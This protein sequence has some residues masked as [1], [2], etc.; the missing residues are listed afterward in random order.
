MLYINNLPITRSTMNEVRYAWST[1]RIRENMTKRFKWDQTAADSIDWYSHGSTIMAREYY[2]RNF[3]MKLIHERLPVLGEDFSASANKVCPCCK[4]RNETFSHYI[5]CPSNPIK[6]NE[7]RDGLKPIYETH[8][9]DPM[10]RILINLALANE[11]ITYYGTQDLYPIN[12]WKP[13]KV[14]IKAQERIGWRQL[15]YGRYVLEWDQCQ[16]R[17]LTITK[18]NPVTGE[19]QWIRE[20]IQ[21]TWRYQKN[22]WLARSETLHGKGILTSQATKDAYFARITALY[23]HEAHILVQDRHPFNTPLEEW[24]SK[25]ATYM[26][27]WLG[28]NAPFIKRCLTVAKLHLKIN[29][30]D[31]R[32][33]ITNEPKLPGVKR[34]RKKPKKKPPKHRDIRTFIP[35]APIPPQDIAPAPNPHPEN[36]R[37]PSKRTPH[38]EHSPTAKQYHQSTLSHFV[39]K[40]PT[41]EKNRSHSYN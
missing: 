39:L 41:E 26:K 6:V 34:R 11:P 18:G 35:H 37:A 29:A 36:T 17:F 16:R 9:I 5:T 38:R 1:Q 28:V 3:S 8:E 40:S 12:D 31:I 13:Y 21:A 7:I 24:P 25:S 22:R 10:L 32:A 4:H 33:F 14:L 2:Q 15:H 27:Q 30:S 23:S 19:P 20:V